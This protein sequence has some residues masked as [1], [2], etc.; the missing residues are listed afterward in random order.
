MLQWKD[1]G[2]IV[3]PVESIIDGLH[4]NGV[5]VATIRATP[6]RVIPAIL[7]YQETEKGK[8]EQLEECSTICE[9]KKIIEKFLKDNLHY[10][11][12]I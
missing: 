9:A 2:N 8:I 12:K 6:N 4:Q 5:R 7:N 1:W 3:N 10:Q 11:P